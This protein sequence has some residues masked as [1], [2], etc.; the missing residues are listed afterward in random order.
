MTSR[1][2]ACLLLL[3]LGLAACQQGTPTAARAG[4]DNRALIDQHLATLA[5]TA[6]GY[7]CDGSD[8]YRACAC[9]QT[10]AAG[11]WTCKGMKKM[12]R[13]MG[14]GTPKCKDR[15]CSCDIYF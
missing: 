11:A 4:D 12:C 5:T 13:D 10:D 3:L 9:A 14:A 1:L 2:L 15:V 8:T 6:Q 7:K